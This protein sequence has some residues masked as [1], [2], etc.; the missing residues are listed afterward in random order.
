MVYGVGLKPFKFFTVFIFLLLQNKRT[1]KE[2]N[3]KVHTNGRLSLGSRCWDFCFS[4]KRWGSE[5]LPQ[6]PSQVYSPQAESWNP[7]WR[8]SAAC[9][10]P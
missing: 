4:F 2:G 10:L 9:S 6:A 7:S 3:H 8:L 1:L 5:Y